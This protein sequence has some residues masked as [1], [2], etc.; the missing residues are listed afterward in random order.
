MAF[1]SEAG[2]VD[3]LTLAASSAQLLPVCVRVL[4]SVLLAVIS[5]SNSSGLEV[6]GLSAFLLFRELRSVWV[7]SL[8]ES[9]RLDRVWENGR[10]QSGTTRLEMLRLAVVRQMPAAA[11]K[12]L[13]DGRLMSSLL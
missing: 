9:A 13:V 12:R 6:F 5:F 2:A 8:L 4:V 1:P 3:E 11:R 7:G 10:T